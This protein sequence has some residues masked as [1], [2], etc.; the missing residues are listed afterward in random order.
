[1]KKKLHD[2][3][4][5]E[6]RED[7][8][9][10]NETKRV[11]EEQKRKMLELEKRMKL[12][13]EKD[14]RLKKYIAEKRSDAEKSKQEK[15]SRQNTDFLINHG[16]DHEDQ[17]EKIRK[18]ELLLKEETKRREFLEKLWNETQYDEEWDNGKDG[19]ESWYEDQEDIP[20][21]RPVKRLII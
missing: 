10:D 4:K 20:S 6:D 16:K 1:M 2:E 19:W 8:E 7:Q 5:I 11:Y 21:K 14:E 18:L 3:S 15:R 12:V 13:H 17:T 9:R